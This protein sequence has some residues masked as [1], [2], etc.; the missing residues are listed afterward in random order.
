MIT[1]FDTLVPPFDTY[2]DL[3]HYYDLA[4]KIKAQKILELGV[5]TYGVSTYA[6]IHACHETGGK[7]TSVDIEEKKHLF[8]DPCWEFIKSDDMALNPL[9]LSPP[10]DIVF[11]D[12]SHTYDHTL[13]ELKRFSPMVRPGGYLIM[14][15]IDYPPVY[16]A[17]IEFFCNNAPGMFNEVITTRFF[18]R[19][20]IYRR[21]E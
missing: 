9:E 12:T 13:A 19:S 8:N 6:W 5:G 20:T 4:V 15:D 10:Y 7:V 1:S 3:Q 17:L 11:I 2:Q 16:E 21:N 18:P 14:H